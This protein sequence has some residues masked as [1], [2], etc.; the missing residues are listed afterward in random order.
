MPPVRELWI[1]PKV[2]AR[3]ATLDPEETQELKRIL[4][5]LAHGAAGGSGDPDPM[6]LNLPT[7][8]NLQW[9]RGE[10]VYVVYYGNGD[11]LVTRIGR[12]GHS[13]ATQVTSGVP[14]I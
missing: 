12:V 8:D 2:V 5:D 14:I 3:A 13:S 7:K 9:V 6:P 1:P 10:R 4:D 11:I